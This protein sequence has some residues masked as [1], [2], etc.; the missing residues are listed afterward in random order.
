MYFWKK[1]NISGAWRGR[2]LTRQWPGSPMLWSSVLSRV[3]NGTFLCIKTTGVDSYASATSNWLD[4]GTECF[5]A[6]FPTATTF[7]FFRCWNP[8]GTPEDETL[9][10]DCREENRSCS[11]SDSIPSVCSSR[12]VRSFRT[13]WSPLRGRWMR[14][15]QIPERISVW[16]KQK[17]SFSM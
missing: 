5:P 15:F 4:S 9:R 16:E 7:D 6:W 14:R 1:P 13:C 11:T 8:S 12:F 3:L 2:V 10:R 17:P